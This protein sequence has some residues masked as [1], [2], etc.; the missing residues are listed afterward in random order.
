MNKYSLIVLNGG[1]GSRLDANQPKQFIRVNGT[2]L[3]I[4][5]LLAVDSIAEISQIIINYPIGYLESTKKLIRDYGIK[6]HIDFV[7]GGSTRQESVHRMLDLVTGDFVIIH[8]SARPAVTKE[9]FLELIRYKKN[10]VG[11]CSP[12]SFTVAPV[13]PEN[14][15]ITGVLERSKLRN[16]QLP[17][18][19][20][21][22]DLR[23]AH[24][25]IKEKNLFFTEDMTLV[26][27]CGF[28]VFYID[29]K[30]ENIKVTNSL[31]LVLT[32]M[33]LKARY[34]NE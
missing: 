29:G 19:F 16:V 11:F 22:S 6:K 27:S 32:E 23:T 30:P 5:S 14:Q 4:Y 12:I 33:I 31:D 2:P 8:E 24:E 13:N 1:V 3:L 9:E 18:K 25:H 21:T 7:E 26:H 28:D 15:K 20:L 34:E 17:Q 10:N